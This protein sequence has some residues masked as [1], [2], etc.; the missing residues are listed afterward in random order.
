MEMR[1]KMEESM[2][3]TVIELSQKYIA[4]YNKG[5][6]V[7]YAVLSKTLYGLFKIEMM[8]YLNLC[9]VLK[10]MLFKINPYTPCV[11]NDD[12]NNKTNDSSM[13]C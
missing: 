1:V 8:F 9:K 12:M 4:Y 7:L 10:N 2:D 6:I 11:A 3:E 13:S 5:I